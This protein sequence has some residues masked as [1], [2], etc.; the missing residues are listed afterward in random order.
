[1]VAPPAHHWELSWFT[2]FFGMDNLSGPFYGA[3][4]GWVSDLGEL[5]IFAGV[6]GMY[7]HK[8][9]HERGCWRLGKHQYEGTPYCHKHHPVVVADP[10]GRSLSE[11]HAARERGTVENNPV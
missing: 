10:G 5:T 9:C 2:H 8:N 6:V 11:I 3:W 1:M 4:S 7:R